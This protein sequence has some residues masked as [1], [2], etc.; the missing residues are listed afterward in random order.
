MTYE[1]RSNPQYNSNE[2]YFEGKPSAAVREALK[3]LKFRWNPT[4]G[5]WYGYAAEE[6]IAGAILGAS[7]EEEPA[8]IVG[9]GY[10]G[11]GSVYGPKSGK[12]LYGSDLSKAIR[13]D[14]KRAVIKGVTIAAKNSSVIATVTTTAADVKTFSEFLKD[15]RPRFAFGCWLPY[16]DE[17]GKVAEI[18]DEQYYNLPAED[19]D[20]VRQQAAALEYRKEVEQRNNVNHYHIDQYTSFT[21][22]GLAKLQQVLSIINAYRYDVS[23]S[24]VD[25]FDT[26]FYIDLYTQPAKRAA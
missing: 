20:R 4:K 18:S 22:S 1:I 3:G 21:A 15:F 14:I 12:H 11:G 2:I 5:C 9:D 8:T 13:E 17:F 16:F 23:N 24:M 6:T 25:Y 26:N 10:M 19:Q 7:T